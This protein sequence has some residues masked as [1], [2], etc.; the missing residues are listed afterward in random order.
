MLSWVVC[1]AVCF[2]GHLK[3]VV[4]VLAR[5]SYEHYPHHISWLLS[6]SLQQL[7]WEV[8]KHS[9]LVLLPV[10][11][12]LFYSVL[13]GIMSLK[14]HGIG[15]YMAQAPSVAVFRIYDI[16]VRRAFVLPF[17]VATLGRIV[18]GAR[19]MRLRHRPC[20]PDVCST[21]CSMWAEC[22]ATSQLSCCK[23]RLSLL[24]IAELSPLPHKLGAP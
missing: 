22:F 8:A 24:C 23:L 1:L 19:T 15:Y 10:T 9:A 6:L 4:H 16:V 14:H 2:A 17:T 5:S 11:A 7:S 18:E 20:N 13:R 12:Q 21:A 3:K